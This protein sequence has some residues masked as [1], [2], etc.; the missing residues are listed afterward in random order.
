MPPETDFDFDKF[1]LLLNSGVSVSA[2]FLD[3][4]QVM[5]VA[6]HVYHSAER[7]KEHDVSVPPLCGKLIEILKECGAELDVTNL[8]M[9]TQFQ[10]AISTGSNHLLECFFN[11]GVDSNKGTYIHAASFILLAKTNH[12]LE[13]Y[14]DEE[15]ICKQ[16]SKMY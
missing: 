1:Q 10:Y 9:W 4:S 8:S 14:E 7:E 12:Y 3:G 2:K 11:L 16:N 5:H 15:K 6:I 13:R